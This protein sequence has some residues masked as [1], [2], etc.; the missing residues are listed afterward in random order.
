MSRR[1]SPRARAA[2][3]TSIAVLLL[4]LEGLAQTKTPGKDD[5]PAAPPSI[6]S[7][8]VD[9]V[10]L[11]PL[12]FVVLAVGSAMFVPAVIVTA[13]G[14]RDNIEG[15]LDFFVITPYQDV[16]ERPLGEF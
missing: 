10:L 7:Q 8:A 1:F 3:L 13:P 9:V 14:G 15:A 2:L 11:R 5:I 16:F 6:I 12:G 4:P